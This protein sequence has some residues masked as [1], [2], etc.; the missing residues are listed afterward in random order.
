MARA[1]LNFV[2]PTPKNMKIAMLA[3]FLAFNCATVQVSQ[4]FVDCGYGAL[5]YSEEIPEDGPIQETVQ[6]EEA[7]PAEAAES[8]SGDPSV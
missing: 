6:E 8:G 3:V 4:A 7:Q 1:L 2:P 5:C